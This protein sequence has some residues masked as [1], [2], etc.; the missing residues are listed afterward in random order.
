M[1][2]R[3]NAG[4]RLGVMGG[5]FDPIHNGHLFIAEAARVQVAL[6]RVLW[7]PNRQPAHREGKIAAAT[8]EVRAALVKLS[9]ADQPAFQLCRLELDRPG[10]SYA[11]DTLAQLRSEYKECEIYW[12]LGADAL[13]DLPTWHRA[14]ELMANCRFIA[15]NRPGFDLQP[16]KNR[17]SPAQQARVTWIEAP[18]IDI[19][20]RQLRERVRH[21]L[22]IRYL[23]PENVRHEI[24]R[25]NL[26][27][28]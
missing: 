9:I 6:H 14:D 15:F 16:L 18:G 19:A 24:E 3:Y 4:V 25:R 13:E 21:N 2:F 11:I 17:L 12:I 26:Y 1:R 10:P 8:A 28:N 7:L 27:Q 22:P 20:S 23:V 5:T